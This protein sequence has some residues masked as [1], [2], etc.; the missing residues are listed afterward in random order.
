MSNDVLPI[1]L[2][3]IIGTH[4]RSRGTEMSN[5]PSQSTENRLSVWSH[6]NIHKA[7]ISIH[8]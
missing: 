5:P 3:H 4:E 6:T 8:V 2:S 1:M 7:D